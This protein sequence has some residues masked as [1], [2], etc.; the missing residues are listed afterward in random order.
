MLF[1]PHKTFG[2]LRESIREYGF[3]ETVERSCWWR[4][5]HS[6]A[7]MLNRNRRATA[8]RISRGCGCHAFFRRE[9]WQRRDVSGKR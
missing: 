5:E 9:T 1:P 4:A 7:S 3:R 6:L 2:K 8:V